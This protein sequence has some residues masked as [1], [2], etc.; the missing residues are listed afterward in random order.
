MTTMT[1]ANKW[2]RRAFVGTALVGAGVT[3][4]A[5]VRKSQDDASA[6]AP[7]GSKPSGDF[8]Y[9]VSEFEKVDPKLVTHQAT[10]SFATGLERVKR[11]TAGL[12]GLVLVAGDRVVRLLKMDGTVQGE[13]ALERPPHCL[14]LAGPDELLVGFG[15]HFGVY[16]LSGRLKRRSP[17]LGDDTFITAIAARERTVYL[18]DAGRRDVLLADA[19]TGE[20]TGRFGRKNEPLGAPGFVVP[21]PYFDLALGRDRLHVTNPGRLRIETYTLDGR[22]ESSWGEPGLAIERF[23][24]CCNPVWFRI[25]TDGR[26]LTSEKGLA[27]VKIYDSNGKLEGVV[28]GPETLV[29]DKELAKRACSDCRLGGAFDVATDEQ[30]RVL[31]LDPFRNTVRIFTARP[32]A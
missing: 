6:P 7:A 4:G 3:T 17:R 15:N 16:D 32:R 11:L 8:A 28:A 13:I 30:G 29:D 10:G 9:D 18:A 5:L 2:T 1:T 27:R 12:G 23:C 22:F 19:A 21:S 24:G 26:F 20:I 25:N 14:H 31:V